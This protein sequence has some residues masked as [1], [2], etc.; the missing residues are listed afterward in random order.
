MKKATQTDTELFAKVISRLDKE[1]KHS[2]LKRQTIFFGAATVLS[3]VVFVLAAQALNS[4][5]RESGFISF[6]SLFFS[7]FKIVFSSLW[8]SFVFSL[9]ESIPVA[10][11]VFFLLTIVIFLESLS[12]FIK[13]IKIKQS[14]ALR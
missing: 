2:A 10:N 9:L 12:L 6:F 4:G 8:Q 13:N 14:L 7:D 11:L 1:A 5:L 3:A